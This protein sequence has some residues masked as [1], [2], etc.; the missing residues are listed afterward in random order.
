MRGPSMTSEIDGA[1]AA[2]GLALDDYF[3]S[4]HG[5]RID[6]RDGIAIISGEFH[7]AAERAV[8]TVIA[9]LVPGVERVE[10]VHLTGTSGWR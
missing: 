3:G 4:G 9:G 5:W 7:D 6:V 1:A 10:L 8:V 2:V